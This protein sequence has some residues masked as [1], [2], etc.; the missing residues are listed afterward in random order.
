MKTIINYLLKLDVVVK[1]HLGENI[2]LQGNLDPCALHGT[3]K[4]IK[5]AASKILDSYGFG[6][7]HIFNLGHGIDQYVDP[8]NLGIL[9]NHVKEYSKKYHQN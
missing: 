6:H 2:S 3:E 9:I 4:S 1:P 8:E 5:E 7:R